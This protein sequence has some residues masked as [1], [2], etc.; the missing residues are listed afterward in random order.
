MKKILQILIILI[1]VA[2]STQINAQRYITEI[3]DSYLLSEDVLFGA[4]VSPLIATFP[5]PAIPAEMAQWQGEMDL[6]NSVIDA[7]VLNP[8]TMAY[9]MN[10][11]Y[12]NALLPDT[13][14]WTMVKVAQLLMDVYTPPASD[15][16][17]NRPVFVNVH[18][19]NFCQL[20]ITVQQPVI[21]LTV[22]A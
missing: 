13:T 20:Y 4:N 10:F 5:N 12:P 22:L 16:V 1:V 8:D 17:T 7:A 2:F 14:Q 11:F 6:L 3:F 9:Y 18:T 21:K 15:E 19:G